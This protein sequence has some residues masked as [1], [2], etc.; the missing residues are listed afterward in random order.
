MYSTRNLIAN[1]GFSRLPHAMVGWNAGQN[2]PFR[3]PWRRIAVAGTDRN[4][5]PHSAY[6]AVLETNGSPSGARLS[7][8]VSI[9]AVPTRRFAIRLTARATDRSGQAGLAISVRESAAGEVVCRKTVQPSTEW[10]R[11]RAE[12]DVPAAT[13][14][15]AIEVALQD[16]SSSRHSVTITDVRLVGLLRPVD[17][18]AVRFDACSDIRR[19]SS[20]LRAFMLEDYLHLLGCRTSLNGGRSFDLLVCQKIQPWLRLFKARLTRKTVVFDIDDNDLLISK[21]RAA[22]VRGFARAVDAVTVGS[23]FLRDL[24]TDWNSRTF[25]LDNPVDILDP[26]VARDDR[27]WKGQLVWFGMPE[28]RWMLDRLD[29]DRPVVTVTRGGSVEYALKSVDEHLV[30]SDLAL[31]P[32]FLNTETLAKNANRLVKCVGLGL[33]FLASDT[34]ENR[35]A[36]RILR[37]PEDFLVATEDD[38]AARIDE[39]GRNY[40]HYRQIIVEARPRAFELYGVERITAGWLQFCNSL[41]QTGA[42]ESR[43]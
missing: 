19:A 4:G 16:D 10:E 22:N 42:A 32:V 15:L 43:L 33:P 13:T 12:F 34:E 31:L 7:Q 8:D 14:R 25:L 1:G 37:L 41:T 21:W 28:N 20:R 36:L 5:I 11:H 17:D 3:A 26:D 18:I 39:V 38:W 2:A 35:R 23:E 27:P 24:V 30:K 9:E 29:L 6:A 40:A